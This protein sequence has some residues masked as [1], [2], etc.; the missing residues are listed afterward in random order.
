M[1]AETSLN[2]GGLS[3]RLILSPILNINLNS[4][5]TPSDRRSSEQELSSIAQRAVNYDGLKE[6]VVNG[7][8]KEYL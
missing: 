7:T 8:K 6:V 3:R 2:F 4:N 5:L 1:I